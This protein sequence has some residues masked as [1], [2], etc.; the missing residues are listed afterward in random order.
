MMIVFDLHCSMGHSFEG[1]F[2]SHEDFSR[3]IDAGIVSCPDCGS[4]DVKK[5][6]SAP[7]LAR[8]R[9]E[10][11][12]ERQESHGAPAPQG[13][14]MIASTSED[15]SVAQ[16]INAPGL[17]RE[18]EQELRTVFGKIR[19]HVEK[20]CDYVG[21]RFAEEARR[22]HYGEAD[23]RGIYGEAS[24]EETAE[25]VEE[26]INVMPIPGVSGKTDA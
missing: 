23:E 11:D 12:G 19:K 8:S 21:D 26:G 2:R 25:L 6:F 10:S 5:G 14:V 24:M 7:H 4:E 18:I 16:A 3:Q 13:G 17:P 15:G 1:W 20:T 22:M 9:G